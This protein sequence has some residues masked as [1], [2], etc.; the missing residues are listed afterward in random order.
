MVSGLVSSMEGLWGGI[1][2]EPLSWKR[3]RRLSGGLKKIEG[4]HSSIKAT[5][6]TLG[7]PS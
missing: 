4:F 6:H 3:L 2:V 5:S 7:N 1:V